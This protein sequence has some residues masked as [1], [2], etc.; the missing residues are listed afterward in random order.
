MTTI[1][2][3]FR[4]HVC[5]PW[6]SFSCI[7]DFNDHFLCS[8]SG[9]WAPFFT[10]G[11]WGGRLAATCHCTIW[12]LQPDEV[13]LMF[14]WSSWFRRRSPTG[15]VWCSWVMAADGW[16]IG[17]IWTICHGQTHSTHTH[18]RRYIIDRQRFTLW[19]LWG[20]IP[21]FLLVLVGDDSIA[22]RYIMVY[23]LLVGCHGAPPEG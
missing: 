3:L 5:H 19:P 9:R 17:S 4:D 21:F 12:N 18:T 16:L 20:G 2:N 11:G 10:I 15:F 1:S 23:H 14:W 6:P 8:D 22:I 13:A 7:V